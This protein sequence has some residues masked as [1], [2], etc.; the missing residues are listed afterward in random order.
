MS[1]KQKNV[2]IAKN[3]S[4]IKIY[5]EKICALYEQMEIQKGI[6]DMKRGNTKTSEEVKKFINNR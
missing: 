4:N 3:I 2:N 5:K 6:E 1:D